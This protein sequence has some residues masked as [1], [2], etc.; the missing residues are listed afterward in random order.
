MVGV[1]LQRGGRVLTV[2][3]TSAHAMMIDE[4]QYN[5]GQGGRGGKIRWWQCTGLLR[6]FDG[7]QV[8]SMLAVLPETFPSR[9]RTCD[10]EGHDALVQGA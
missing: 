4:I 9:K 6:M 2:A 3:S 10:V 8:S 7:E 1:T 5:N